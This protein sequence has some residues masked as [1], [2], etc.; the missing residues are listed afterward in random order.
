MW[1]FKKKADKPF[2]FDNDRDAL[3][4]KLRRYILVTGVLCAKRKYSDVAMMMRTALRLIEDFQS[5][6]R[7]DIALARLRYKHRNAVVLEKSKKV[8]EEAELC[9]KND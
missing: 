3:I 6:E 7:Y 5:V 1:F 4:E 8:E 9:Q 2:T